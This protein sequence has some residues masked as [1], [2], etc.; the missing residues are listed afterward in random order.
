MIE[1]DGVPRSDSKQT[2]KPSWYLHSS[3]RGKVGCTPR[4]NHGDEEGHTGSKT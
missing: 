2:P 1:G 3:E 4:V